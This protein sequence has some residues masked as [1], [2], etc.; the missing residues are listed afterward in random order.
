M[1][2]VLPHPPGSDLA[3]RKQKGPTLSNDNPAL[4]R[5]WHPVGTIEEIG[6]GPAR[7]MLFGEPWVVVRLGGELTAFVDRCPHRFA[8]LSR[9][10]IVDDV[11]ECGYHGWRYNAAGRCTLIPAL[12]EAGPV[13]AGAKVER[14]F[15]VTERYGLIW[16]AIQAPV[17][18]ILE[19]PEWDDPSLL[20]GMLQPQRC[21]ITA[22]WMIDNFL[23]FAHFPFLHA[24]TI[25][26]SEGAEVDEYRVTRE[27][28]SFG[29]TYTGSF[30]NLWDPGVEEGIRPLVQQRTMT[31]RY[32]APFTLLV[33]YDFHDTDQVLVALNTIQPE[34]EHQSRLYL[35]L[36]DSNVEGG[37][38]GMKEALAFEQ[39]VIDEDLGMQAVYDAKEMPLDLHDEFHTRADRITVELR[40]VLWDLVQSAS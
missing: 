22:G 19:V 36:L 9:G 2:D 28:W 21:P 24:K 32:R 12:G 4:R 17:A 39:A 26:A 23:D 29:L 35:T 33:R 8:P 10:K 14:A 25:G 31:Y 1:V 38:E 7:V 40:R 13:P 11:L 18:D 37:E 27:G 30:Q 6:D 34:T 15:G 16:L 5:W 3:P 20:K